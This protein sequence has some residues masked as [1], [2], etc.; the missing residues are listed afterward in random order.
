MQL[1]QLEYFVVIA[2][3]KSMN[4]AAEKLFISQPALSLQIKKLEEELGCTATIVATGG[5]A[6][7]IIPLCRRQMNLEHD[8][9]LKGLAAIYK[10]NQRPRAKGFYL[11]RGAALACAPRAAGGAQAAVC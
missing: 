3:C 2:D 11:P 10:K 4:K 9:L 7:F 5:M 8:L 1:H 6:Q